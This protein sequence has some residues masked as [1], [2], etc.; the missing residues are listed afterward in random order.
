M[1]NQFGDYT[2]F[3]EMSFAVNL[4]FGVWEG[5]LDKLRKDFQ[6]YVSRFRASALDD[7]GAAVLDAIQRRGTRLI[8]L[9][10]GIKKCGR[11]FGMLAAIAISVIMFVIGDEQVV[12]IWPE[13]IIFSILSLPV[14]LA[15]LSMFMLHHVFSF[16]IRISFADIVKKPDDSKEAD[17]V[18]GS[19]R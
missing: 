19:F 4:L 8:I 7:D 9:C 13:I 16:W 5:L 15:C 12:R 18:L 3:L 6:I 10:D 1:P 2:S 17:R 11:T 14:P